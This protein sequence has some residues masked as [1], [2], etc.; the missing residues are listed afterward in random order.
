MHERLKMKAENSNNRTNLWT[1]A[2]VASIAAV[3]FQSKAATHYVSQTSP[4]PTPPYSSTETAAHNIQDAVDVS[5]DGDTVLVEPGDYSLANQVTVTKG[6]RLQ[7]A[8]GPSQT[9]LT[10]Q[11]ASIWGLWMSNSLAVADGLTF[12]PQG[13]C[14]QGAFVVGGTLQNCNFTNYEIGSP[15]AAIVINGGMVSNSIVTYHR[16]GGGA[17]VECSDALVT[18][19]QILGIYSSA[20]GS[21]IYL[22]NSHLQNSVISGVSVFT[23]SPGGVA[24]YALGRSIWGSTAGDN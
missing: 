9:F 5:T 7:S 3:A 11:T 18:D 17:A 19:S 16:G 6:I 1:L 12:R 22:T 20:Y 24:G 21:A 4:S 13:C 10:T 2:L 8:S 15:R 14:G 23:P